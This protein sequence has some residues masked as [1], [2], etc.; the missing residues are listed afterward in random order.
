[1][2]KIIKIFPI[3]IL[4]FFVLGLFL[5]CPLNAQDITTFDNGLRVIVREDHRKP[6]VVFSAF[7]DVGSASE[8]KYLGCGASHLVEHMLFKGTKKYPRGEIEDIL[9]K[10]GGDIAGWTSYDYTGFSI[11][12]LKE[13][14]DTALDILKE[15]L[16]QPLFDEKE[17]KKEKQVIEREMDMG[18]DDPA[19]RVSRLTFSHAYISHPYRVPIIGYKENFERF[20]RKDIVE[21][22]TSRYTPEKMV[23]SIVGDVDTGEML[24]SVR[25]AFGPASRGNNASVVLPRESEQITK[26]QAEERLDIDG[27]YLNVAFHSTGLLDKDLYAMDILSFILGGG[28]SSLLNRKIRMDKQL[29]LSISAYNYTPKDPGLFVI[30]SVLKEQ[31]IEAALAGIINEIDNIK[32]NSVEA[33]DLEKAK[34]IFI[35]DH[36]YGKE[37][38]GSQGSD[39]ATAMLLTGDPF[40][41]DA[42]TENI[43]SVSADDIKRV[44]NKYLN[45]DNMTI[46]AVTGSGD[47]LNAAGGQSIQEAA[48]EIKKINLTNGIPVLIC[49]D[50]SL[51]LASVSLLMEGG[52]RSET[53]KNNGISKLTSL[54]FEDGTMS[55]TREELAFFY[56]SRGMALGAYSGNN[57]NGIIAKCLKKDTEDAFMLVS[58]MLTNP[59]FLETEI[60]REKKEMLSAIAM[61]DNSVFNH[62]H[63]LLKKALFGSHPYG[64][65]A[66]GTSESIENINRADVIS[67]YENIAF[68]GNIVL[69]V[70]GDCG[71]EEAKELAEKYFGSLKRATKDAKEPAKEALL[72]EVKN[73]TASTEKEQSLVLI[74]FRGISIYDDRKYACRVMTGILS[75]ASGVFFKKIREE[76][77]LSYA[78]GAF[79]APGVDPGYIAIYALTSKENIKKV[80]DLMLKEVNLF[81]KNGASGEELQKSKNHLRAMRQMDTQRASDFMFSSALDE[82]YGLGYDNYKTYDKSIDSVT[83]DDIRSLAASVLTA[84]KCVIV[85]LEGK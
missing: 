65:Q 32:K 29:V 10:Y 73:I 69:A 3:H 58:D 50:R 56:E 16:T 77:A 1:M 38:I 62:G 45:P 21:F 12:I 42:Y 49:E 25:K 55:M 76:N 28:E 47:A 61:Q 66:I 13:H 39:L 27:A 34:N 83:K 18:R 24:G 85:T 68:P 59:A 37:T 26:R 70:S 44:A 2:P 22:F 82:L 57:S 17:L 71:A 5:S 31:N 6:L 48:R 4:A 81:V 72:K 80:K 52:L 30:S 40:F 54:M 20:S 33:K 74:G 35:A 63:R 9:H 19:R 78:T 46:A 23:L 79:Q 15:M 67:F 7:V 53:E 75:S 41:F 11:T 43:Q 8:G 64:F 60:G 14:K 84:D 36:I 51:P